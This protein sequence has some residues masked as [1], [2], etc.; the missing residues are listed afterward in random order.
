MRVGIREQ[1]LAVATGLILWVQPSYAQQEPDLDSLRLNR[2]DS[3]I[4]ALERAALGV[5][6]T[7]NSGAAQL[8]APQEQVTETAARPAFLRRPNAPK[9]FGNIDQPRETVEELE[10]DLNGYQDA[11]TRTTFYLKQFQDIEVMNAATSSASDSC[12]VIQKAILTEATNAFST[13]KMDEL[14][15]LALHLQYCRV[16]ESDVYQ[17][18]DAVD[19]DK[20][21]TTAQDVIFLLLDARQQL[22][23]AKEG[24]K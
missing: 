16:T 6:A 21:A 2:L 17:S 19:A 9:C 11:A 1:I 14:N 4:A 23:E 24:C 15:G 3:A 8:S 18:G 13:V 22:A 7:G 5:T 12:S 20:L 10:Q